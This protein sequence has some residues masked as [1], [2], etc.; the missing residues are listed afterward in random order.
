MYYIEESEVSPY[1]KYRT[2]KIRKGDTLNSV[3]LELGEEAR[4][5]RRYHNIYCPI[6]DLIEA[7]FK[8]HLE[9][10]ILEPEK[11]KTSKKEEIEKKPEKVSFG[12]NYKLPFLSGSVKKE[13]EV[14]Y[15]TEF[16]DEIDILEL[17]VSVEWLAEDKNGFHLLEIN[18][19][20]DIYINAKAPD[21]VMEEL[22]AKTAEILYP[23][24]IVVD[25][26]G[27]WIDIFNYNEIVVRWKHIKRE[28]LDY[29]ESEVTDNHIDAIE[30]ALEDSDTLLATLSSDYFLRAFFNGIHV[31][32]TASF[33]LEDK[34]SFPL[35][36]SKEAV[37][38]IEQKVSPYLD[39]SGFIKV[40]QKGD[41]VDTE[42]NKLYRHYQF[43]GNYNAVYYLNADTYCIE[44]LNLECFIDGDEMIKA[45]IVI[46]PLKKEKT[47]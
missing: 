46:E 9:F 17:K 24:K 44:K 13:Y 8:S 2:Y 29:Y 14:A 19:G 39:E 30:Y 7:D 23:L 4:E 35:E 40:E 45:T 3:A 36:K 34:I 47:E 25:E 12:D 32:Y 37:Y 31:A 6:A 18:R 26:S 33:S 20:K 42:F 5:L 38:T 21:T 16:G 43:K 41:Y 27:K 11:D 28:I 22:D 15:T 10:L 1:H